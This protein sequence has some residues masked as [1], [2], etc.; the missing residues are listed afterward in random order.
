MPF[1]VC[2][3]LPLASLDNL[4]PSQMMK[5]IVSYGQPVVLCQYGVKGKH[6]LP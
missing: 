3:P 5:A 1:S 2:L 6:P 4:V